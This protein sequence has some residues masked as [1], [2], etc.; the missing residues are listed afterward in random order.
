MPVLDITVD[1]PGSL[2]F[3]PLGTILRPSCGEMP[4]PPRESLEDE[5]LC[6]VREDEAKKHMGTR[7]VREE[8][9]LHLC[10]PVPATQANATRSRAS[11]PAEPF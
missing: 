1:W 11:Q 8:D 10:S 3:L 6:L 4:K 2:L 5:M 7:K 9:N